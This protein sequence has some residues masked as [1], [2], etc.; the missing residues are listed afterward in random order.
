M[1]KRFRHVVFYTIFRPL[2]R[3][4]IWIRYRYWGKK[5]RNKSV[6]GPYLILG[7]HTMNADPFMLALSFR[8]PIYFVASDMIFTIPFF[9]KLISYFVQPISKSKYKSD[10]ETVKNMIRVAKSGGSIGIFPEGN[11]TFSGKLMNMPYSTAKLIK[12]LKIPVLFYRIEGGYLTSPR[13]SKKLRRGKVR[14]YVYKTWTYDEYKDLSLDQIYECLSVG[15]G[16]NDFEMQKEAPRRFKGKDKAEYIER[17]FFIS[18]VTNQ[19]D[20]I[21]SKG[22]E[23]FD[24]SSNLHLKYNEY[25]LFENLGNTKFFDNTILWYTHQVNVV[26]QM[27][28]DDSLSLISWDV[29]KVYE[30]KGRKQISLG[31][32]KL[33]LFKDHFSFTIESKECVWKFEDIYPAVQYSN[34]FICYNK[35]NEQTL[36]FTGNERFCALKYVLFAKTY[37]KVVLNYDTEL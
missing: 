37:Q 36:F 2:F 11:R 9:S 16:V 30:L 32:S 13:W 17:A 8:E 15:L 34:T 31:D 7:N 27:V 5:Y 28:Q 20:T 19:M 22:D 6:K 21:Y 14:G 35:Q 29:V 3:I 12:L 24:K 4:G 25:G 10:T 1:K 18:P 23:V 33:T 26:E